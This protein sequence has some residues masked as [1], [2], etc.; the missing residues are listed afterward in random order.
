MLKREKAR[1]KRLK[2][3]R[4]KE[5]NVQDRVL[6]PQFVSEDQKIELNKCLDEAFAAINLE[7]QTEADNRTSLQKLYDKIHGDEK[8]EIVAPPPKKIDFA[9][10]AREYVLNAQSGWIDRRWKDLE[11]LQEKLA[12]KLESADHWAF[13][14][15]KKILPD[16][17]AFWEK[18][19][20]NEWLIL[21]LVYVIQ[22]AFSTS[23]REDCMLT[24]QFWMANRIA[25]KNAITR[26]N[27]PG[28]LMAGL[29]GL[30]QL[31][32]RIT[33]NKGNDISVEAFEP[34]HYV[35]DSI[36]AIRRMMSAFLSSHFIEAIRNIIMIVV[37]Y[38]LFSKDTASS[39][40]L[41]LGKVSKP[42]SLPEAMSRISENVSDLVRMGESLAMGAPP[43][44][45]FLSRDPIQESIIQA[46]HLLS[47]QKMLYYGLA[48]EGKMCAK[49][50]VR[51]GRELLASMDFLYK[52][53][54][55][56][57]ECSK[58]VGDLMI[59]LREAVADVTS[60][61]LRTRRIAPYAVVIV[62]SPGIGKSSLV[63]WFGQRFSKSRG[64]VFDQSHQYERVK[65]SQ[66][67]EGYDPFSHPIIHYS[68][69]GSYNKTM[70][71]NGAE[72]AVPELISM[73]DSIPFCLD[74]AEATSKGK[75]FFLSEFVII[76]TNNADMNIKHLMEYPGAFKRRMLFVEPK[77][78]DE[79]KKPDTGLLDSRIILLT[80]WING[81]SVLIDGSL[82]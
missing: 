7:V 18:L 47:M 15:V 56:Y 49:E 39:I 69:V 43:S 23:F 16:D 32:R 61:T 25:D 9:V 5:R 44:S 57:K 34:S 38:H 59:R 72:T 58:Q 31:R 67:Y 13:S 36:N 50:Y 4:R 53:M 11:R 64:R 74:M 29:L 81:I 26:P 65:T 52:K 77:V 28:P 17:S 42:A 54:N 3:Q 70:A 46:T 75:V 20:G 73:I 79:F 78:K 41:W 80:G 76:D 6:F 24:L 27:L 60:Y 10:V 62:G 68:E 71:Q 35:S 2:K 37:S 40:S 63:N 48:V 66:Y 82:L 12:P 14:L 33:D 21:C 8:E 22:M 1:K 51:Q 45:I 30:N 19:Q 55:P